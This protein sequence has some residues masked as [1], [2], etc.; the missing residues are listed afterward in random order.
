MMRAFIYVQH[1]L[2]IGHLVRANRIATALLD[3][4]FEVAMATGGLPIAGFPGPGVLNI[5]LPPVRAGIAGFSALEDAEGRPVDAAFEERRRDRLIAA[6]LEFKPD[7]VIVEAF[8]FGRRAMRFELLPFLEAAH[9]MQK[10]PLVACSIRDILQKSSKP[11]RAEETATFVETYFDV[12]LVHGDPKFAA[13][14]ETFALADRV[15]HKII[16]TGLVAGPVP[17]PPSERFDIVVS[18]GG[19]AVGQQFISAAAGMAD[20]LGGQY[21]CCLITGPNFSSD[22]V[23]SLR[24]IAGPRA[25]IFTFR[26]DFPS[27]LSTAKLSVSQAGY[28]TLMDVLRAGCRS[29]LVPY[30]QDGENEQTSRALRLAALGLASVLSEAA[31]NA[32]T[33]TEAALA[34]LARPLP[35]PHALDLEGARHTV[36]IL[37]K[38]L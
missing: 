7:V 3:D 15:A 37:R 24:Q 31:V 10:R 11:G 16:Y 28:N 21:S 36:E 1:L 26:K 5:A 35:L 38:R 12:V 2:G 32:S 13:F 30:A 20:I 27:L 9:A 4:G 25:S 22:A 33:L 34:A 23:M 6:L 17:P 19:G 29:L 8:P 14:G 18:A